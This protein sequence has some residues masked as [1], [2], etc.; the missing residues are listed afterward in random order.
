VASGREEREDA[1]VNG[2]EERAMKRHRRTTAL[3]FAAVAVFL[4]VALP[5]EAATR[6]VHA[7]QSIQAAIDAAK[8][9]DTILVDPGVYNENLTITTNGLKLRGAGEGSTILDGA[10]TPDGSDGIDVF[11]QFDSSGNPTTPVEGVKID[12]FTIRHFSGFGVLLV[13]AKNP[14]VSNSEAAGN[15]SYGISGFVLS[16]V[17]FSANVS[18]DN[19]DPGFY[20]GDSPNAD[21]KLVGNTS[22][23]N[24]VG[25]GEGFGFLLRD[26]SYGD[27]RGNTAYG[28]CAGM[29][30]VDSGENPAPETHWNVEHNLVWGNDGF[31]PGGGGPPPTSGIGIAVFGGQEIHV[32]GNTALSNVPSGPSI[33]SGG[34][35]VISFAAGGGSDPSRDTIDGNSAHGNVSYDIFW[36]GSG[37]KNKFNHNDCGTSSPSWIC[38]S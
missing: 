34:I 25:G 36:D 38:S 37:S 30:F 6:H 28:N 3:V 23:R 5:A 35:V 24:G 26:S 8:P 20:V 19:G 4:L 17:T 33:A 2:E 21:A 22:Y 15:G 29:V 12:G 7:G 14:T 11:G 27:V 10:G 1:R 32:H 18:H 13:N 16:G 31:C 9:G